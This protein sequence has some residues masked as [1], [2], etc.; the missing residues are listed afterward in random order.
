MAKMEV[1]VSF[2]VDDGVFQQIAEDSIGGDVSSLIKQALYDSIGESVAT[3]T[4][5]SIN[6][7]IKA[8]GEYESEAI[9]ALTLMKRAF[10]KPADVQ[11]EPLPKVVMEGAAE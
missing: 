5:L 3:I 7:K 10:R 11:Q 8:S 2:I 4:K 9:V 6:S 1:K